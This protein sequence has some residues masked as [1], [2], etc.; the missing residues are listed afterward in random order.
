MRGTTEN[1]TFASSPAGA[2]AR[3]ST[4]MVCEATPCTFELPRDSQ[5]SVVFSKP[6]YQQQQIFVGTHVPVGGGAALAGNIL[7]GGIIGA[8]VDSSNGA[9]LEHTPNPVFATLEPEAPQPAPVVERKRRRQ[10]AVADSAQ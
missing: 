10:Q 4:G 3:V 7:A 8:A 1:V 5:F 9:T 2:T 6:G